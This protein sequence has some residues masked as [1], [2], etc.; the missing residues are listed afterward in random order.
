M[1]S[2]LAWANVLLCTRQAI[3]K[4]YLPERLD[5]IVANYLGDL[6]PSAPIRLSRRV[7]V[8][9]E[10]GELPSADL[11]AY[12]NSKSVALDIGKGTREQ[13]ASIR[14]RARV[15]ETLDV[16]EYTDYPSILFDLSSE[17][18]PRDLK[19]KFDVIFCFSILEHVPNPIV[20]SRN[21][22]EMLKSGGLIVGYVPWLF[23]Y[24]AGRGVR[25]EGFED[26]WRFSPESLGLL[27]PEA[28]SIDVFPKRGRVATALL[29]LFF[30]NGR[31][32][33]KGVEKR[34]PK[35]TDVI[36]GWKSTDLNRWQAS[37][38]EFVV[39]KA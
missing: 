17:A 5:Y 10:R 22:I 2:L 8:R 16:F 21:L 9:E 13:F 24:H 26:Y 18:L 7:V 20:A 6:D 33:W 12:V 35:L 32:F 11:A 14:G 37:G 30:S 28:R 25:Q 23:P 1:T 34:V 39:R 4:Q 15:V 36:G 29:V 27:F 19:K 31:N 3:L 38:Y